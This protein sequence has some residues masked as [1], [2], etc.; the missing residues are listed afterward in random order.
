MKSILILMDKYD[1]VGKALIEAIEMIAIMVGILGLAPA[2]MWL[3]SVEVEGFN[4]RSC[5]RMRERALFC[6]TTMSGPHGRCCTERRDL[7]SG[8]AWLLRLQQ[9]LL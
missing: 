4:W 1:D 3:S 2:L 8:G 9:R 6:A 5:A 7:H